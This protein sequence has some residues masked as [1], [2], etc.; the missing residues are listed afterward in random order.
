MVL[1]SNQMVKN[2]QGLQA[3]LIAATIRDPLQV[4]EDLL[5]SDHLSEEISEL[6]VRDAVVGEAD[7]V[8]VLLGVF[9]RACQCL[10]L[11]TCNP[12]VHQ[13]V[14][15]LPEEVLDD[16][17]GD[18]KSVVLAVALPCKLLLKVE[19]LFVVPREKD[20]FNVFLEVRGSV[21]L[22]HKGVEIASLESGLLGLL[23][24]LTLLKYLLALQY[25]LG[26]LLGE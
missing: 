13:S 22:E 21:V 15:I 25:E 4:I 19:S 17:G 3:K 10:R 16:N 20:A 2:L 24:A 1:L 9:E 12:G 23:R 6:L 5:I 18:R 11:L 8:Y 7:L 26:Y 14:E